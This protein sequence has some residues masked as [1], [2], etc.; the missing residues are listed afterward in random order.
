MSRIDEEKTQ[1]TKAVIR[2]DLMDEALTPLRKYAFGAGCWIFL[3]VILTII[4]APAF[5]DHSILI[6]IEAVI[7]IIA[8]YGLLAFQLWLLWKPL[9]KLRQI[10]TMD[11]SMISVTV[12][13]VTGKELEKITNYN[14]LTKKRFEENRYICFAAHK[15]IITKNKTWYDFLEKGKTCYVV[16]ILPDKGTALLFYPTDFYCYRDSAFAL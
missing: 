11:D 6:K 14:T 1:L 12:D 3:A 2:R 13:T 16:S 7:I 9:R 5:R 8:I 15:S 10:K 4:A